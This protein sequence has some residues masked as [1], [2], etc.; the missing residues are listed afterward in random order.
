MGKWITLRKIRQQLFLEMANL[1]MPGH[2][3]RPLFVKWGGVKIE[4]Y[5]HTFIGKNCVFDG[6]RP[7]N[8]TIEKGV[9]VTEGST[10]ITHYFNPDTGHYDYG[11]VLIKERAFIGSRTIV[12]K[13]V[14]I[15]TDSVVGA[16]SIVTK[17]IPDG[18][19]WAG[20][21]AKFLR[22]KK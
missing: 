7:E 8:I 11:C 22:Y 3:W 1:P 19:I 12:T 16:G 4:D 6:V 21:P 5:K 18:E 17:D 9:R 15:G 20:N 10:I 13:P 14:V 2:K